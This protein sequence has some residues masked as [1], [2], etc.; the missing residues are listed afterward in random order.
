M[1][2]FF[3]LLARAKAVYEWLNFTNDAVSMIG[4]VKRA[5][6]A[7]ATVAV[8]AG[9]SV[10]VTKGAQ[11]VLQSPQERA[12]KSAIAT[13]APEISPE[14][15]AQVMKVNSENTYSK[16]FLYDPNNHPLLEA[17]LALCVDGNALPSTQCDDAGK[18]KARLVY[19]E[20]ER[21]ES[22]RAKA[23]MEKMAKDLEEK[24]SKMPKQEWW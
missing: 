21:E 9:A 19:E 2:P 18:V 23:Y 16:V 5:A 17:I 22:A 12:I 15:R 11:A 4:V 10:G 24:V 13:H 3:G 20:R 1:L 14:I 8:V 6:A 7:T